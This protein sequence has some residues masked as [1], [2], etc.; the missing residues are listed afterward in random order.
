MI[1]SIYAIVVDDEKPAR[2]EMILALGL[3][4]QIKVLE[5]CRN[6]FDAIKAIESLKPDVVFLDIE[7]PTLSGF[8]LIKKLTYLPE[9]IFCTAFDNY[10]INAFEEN[11][12]DY[13]LKPIQ[14]ERLKKTIEKLE[15]KIQSNLY[16]DLS[17][18]RILLQNGK[19]C[20][21]TNLADIYLFESDGNYIKYCFGNKQ[22]LKLETL[23]NLEE[24]LPEEHFLKINRSQIINKNHIKSTRIDGRHLTISLKND[25]TLSVSRQQ[26]A[27]FKNLGDEMV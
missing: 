14:A 27:Y 25:M 10:A 26:T 7:M 15:A 9:I 19:A 16:F 18:K 24:S 21:L 8:E 4:P 2:E 12:L 20:Y 3:H 11:A 13:L 6:A 23:K 5:Q 22:I 17:S 1:N